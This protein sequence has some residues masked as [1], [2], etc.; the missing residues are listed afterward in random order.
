[1]AERAEKYGWQ[2]L[3]QRVAA[4][5]FL[6]DPERRILYGNPAFW[7][8]TGA[9]AEQL[10]GRICRHHFSAPPGSE[11]ALLAT[12]APPLETLEGKTASVCRP[13]PDVSNR[14]W[15]LDFFPLG[16]TNEASAMLGRIQAKEAGVASEAARLPTKLLGLRDRIRRWHRL[17]LVRGDGLAMR[18]VLE[19]VRLAIKTAGP[20]WIAGEPG[21]GKQWLARVIHLESRLGDRGFHTLDCRRLPPAWVLREITS[22]AG[23]T[24]AGRVGTI[25][26]RQPE[27]LPRD[28]QARI[29]DIFRGGEEEAGGR[30]WPRLLIGSTITPAAAA[31]DAAL[32]DEFCCRFSP[33][34]IHMPP[35]RARREELRALAEQL[36]E[37]AATT[38][39]KAV[40]GLTAEAWDVLLAAT[41]P[42]NL[43]ELHTVLRQACARADGPLLHVHDLPWYLRAAP[44]ES[45]RKLVLDDLLHEVE[46]RLVLLALER[47]KEKRAGKDVVNKSRAATLLSVWRARLIRRLKD[48]GIEDT[49]EK[50]QEDGES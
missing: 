27:H 6:L 22:A 32:V 30:N 1:V 26:L 44:A 29:V 3:F 43:R 8:L 21:T 23:G 48:L 13:A 14:L 36:L 17:D 15:Q 16:H 25:Y 10:E 4:P 45:E 20:V 2:R 49:D 40:T 38:A 19:Q 39:G 34:T 37:R 28:I 42:D 11:E 35:L 31:T 9:S 7:Q 5:L 50:S 41:W 18:R 46:R 12:L 47:S 33:L 24:Q